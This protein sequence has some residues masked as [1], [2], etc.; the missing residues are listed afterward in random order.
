MN[1]AARCQIGS[2]RS[3][4]TFEYLHMGYEQQAGWLSKPRNV[5]LRSTSASR[6][7]NPLGRCR[8]VPFLHFAG[9]LCW[10]DTLAYQVAVAQQTVPPVAL[11]NYSVGRRFVRRP[12]ITARSRHPVPRYGL[13]SP[14]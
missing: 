8:V 7:T 2:D 9:E 1:T 10:T 12:R 5:L 3:P 4:W 6:S 14:P 13:A 11:A